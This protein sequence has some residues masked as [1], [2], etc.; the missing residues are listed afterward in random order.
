MEIHANLLLHL[1]GD[2]DMRYCII[3]CNGFFGWKMVIK[4]VSIAT[5]CHEPLTKSAK[6]VCLCQDPEVHWTISGNLAV[7]P[8]AV[9]IADEFF[10]AI[11]SHRC[12][13]SK[14]CMVNKNMTWTQITRA[15]KIWPI[16]VI[17]QKALKHIFLPSNPKIITASYPSSTTND[18]TNL[19]PSTHKWQPN[20]TR[21]LATIRTYTVWKP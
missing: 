13:L 1:G 3:S 7:R 5:M 6:C 8:E 10:H 16:G 9:V 11:R 2:I 21:W 14:N 20:R 17:K 15:I 4:S 18:T 12:C 19:S